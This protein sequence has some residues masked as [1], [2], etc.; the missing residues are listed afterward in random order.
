MNQKALKKLEY[1]KIIDE[2]SSLASSSLGKELCNK[3]LPFSDLTTITAAQQETADALS[4]I[5]KNG[6]LSL[7]GIKDI[8]SSLKHLEVGGTLGIVELLNVSSLLD[9]ALRAKSYGKKKMRKKRLIP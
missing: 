8:R 5:L 1:N 2:L 6:S 7:R 9:C 4:R 3:L